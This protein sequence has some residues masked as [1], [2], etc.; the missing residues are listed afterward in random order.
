MITKKYSQDRKKC[1]VAFKLPVDT[2]SETVQLYGEFTNWVGQNMTRQKKGGFSLSITLP[3]GHKYQFRYLMDGNRWEND[4]DAD[5]FI[6][7]P[8]GS[9]DSVLD[10]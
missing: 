4:P 7:N 6:P 10:I 3:A 8:Y 2:N 1:R 9:E 5:T